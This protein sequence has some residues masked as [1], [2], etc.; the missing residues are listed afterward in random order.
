LVPDAEGR[1]HLI[2]LNPIESSVEPLFN[3]ETEIVFILR[4]LSNLEGERIF[5]NDM[6]SVRNSNYNPNN[7]T[8]FTVHGWHGSGDA[9][10][11]WRVA[12][13]LFSLGDY[14]VS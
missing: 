8:R 9:S 4:T 7:P 5:W 3:P 2:D 12:Q 13:R 11:N 10:V 6:N 14:N 1:I